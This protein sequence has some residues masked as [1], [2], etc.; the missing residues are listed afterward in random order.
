MTIWKRGTGYGRDLNQFRYILTCFEMGPTDDS[1]WYFSNIQSMI[2]PWHDQ[3]SGLVADNIRFLQ[4]VLL[5]GNGDD[6]MGTVTSVLVLYNY[7]ILVSIS[8]QEIQKLSLKMHCHQR[9]KSINCTKLKRSFAWTK[10]PFGASPRTP[11]K[12]TVYWGIFDH[13]PPTV[14]FSASFALVVSE[15]I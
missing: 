10:T 7:W 11:T 12:D 4:D 14:F 15:W 2:L 8:F 13:I 5:N 6:C 1:R 9:Y 3:Q